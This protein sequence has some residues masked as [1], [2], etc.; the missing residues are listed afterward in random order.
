[1]ML[2]P[3]T[4]KDADFMLELKNYPETRMFAISSKKKIL[5]RDHRKWL[6]KNIQHFKIIGNLIDNHGYEMRGVIRIQD[7]EISIWIDRKYWGFG[8][9]SDAINFLSYSGLI[10]RIVDGNIGSM[11]AFINA[12]FKPIEHK[13]NYYIFQK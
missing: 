2:R 10:A 11:R 6:E 1:M 7:N 12:G 13:N 5:K 4:I 9:A 3:M 8:V